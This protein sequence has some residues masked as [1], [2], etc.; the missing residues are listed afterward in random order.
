MRR[1]VL[2]VLRRGLDNSIANWPLILIRLGATLLYGMIA[3]IG[4]IA[5]IVPTLVS[6]G[7]RLQNIASPDDIEGMIEILLRQWPIF[8]WIVVGIM[9]LLLVFIAIHSFVTAGC[10]RVLVDGERIAG[11]ALEGPRTR[12]RLF[13][14]DRW[15]AGGTSGW[16]TV[17]WIYN[18]AW[19]VAGLIMLI[20]LIPTIV[21]MFVFHEEPQ[22]ALGIGCLG[23]AVTLLLIMIVGFFTNIWTTRAIAHWAVHPKGASDALAHGWRALKADVGR[24]VL[25][26]LAVI[27][28]AF[29]GSAFFASFS[30]FAAFGQ[31]IGDQHGMFALATFPIRIIASLASTA[32]SAAVANW[33]LAAYAALAVE[34][35]R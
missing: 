24:H 9:V 14:M 13:A 27:V 3:V 22:A 31:A 10:A 26:A 34:M 32:F 20:P 1:G 15:M 30:F 29:A 11:P 2:D 16:W 12:Y 5:I 6:V 25:S 19:G 35:D 7:I 18:L 17:F 21:L 23:L 8:V 4:A 28:V 33:Y